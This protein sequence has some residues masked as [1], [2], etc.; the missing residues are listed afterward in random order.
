MVL[1][2]SLAFL[3][4]DLNKEYSLELLK[5]NLIPINSQKGAARHSLISEVPLHPKPR[6]LFLESPTVHSDSTT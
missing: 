3:I 4:L 5:V 6:A 2:A 1:G